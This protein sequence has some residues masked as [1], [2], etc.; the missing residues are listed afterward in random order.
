MEEKVKELEDKLQEV[1]VEMKKQNKTNQMLSTMKEETEEEDLKKTLS[2]EYDK[3]IKKYKDLVKEMK[4]LMKKVGEITKV[5]LNQG[6]QLSGIIR[7]IKEVLKNEE[8]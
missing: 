8:K 7:L 5:D 4:G 3:G 2:D 6:L 1:N